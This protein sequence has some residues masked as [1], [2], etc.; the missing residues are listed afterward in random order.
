MKVF[1]LMLHPTALIF[2]FERFFA[3]KQGRGSQAIIYLYDRIY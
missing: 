1:R 3:S 2:P